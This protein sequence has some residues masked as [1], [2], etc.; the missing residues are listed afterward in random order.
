MPPGVAL[1]FGFTSWREE[2]A[3]INHSGCCA[4]ASIPL[5]GFDVADDVAE[6]ALDPALVVLRNCDAGSFFSIAESRAEG[7][8][9][10]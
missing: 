2:V 9:K 5:F 3:L 6:D 1:G 10:F 7:G 8:T 4:A